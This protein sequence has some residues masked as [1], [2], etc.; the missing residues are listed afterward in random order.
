MDTGPP[1]DRQPRAPRRHPSGRRQ[2]A[3]DR[4]HGSKRRRAEYRRGLRHRK[5]RLGGG[6]QSPVP[7]RLPRVRAPAGRPHSHRRRRR[8]CGRPCR[9][10]GDL[11][12]RDRRVVVG[13]QYDL[14]PLSSLAD[15]PQRW[16]GPR[17]RWRGVQQRRDIRPRNQYVGS[18]SGARSAAP[19]SHGH[20]PAGRTGADRR[21]RTQTRDN[22]GHRRNLRSP[23]P[24]C[25]PPPA[26]W[27][28]RESLIAPSC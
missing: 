6:R 17:I 24:T 2:G 3:C 13:R 4:R 11:R 10:G 22:R 20:A 12:P 7:P 18:A 8:R 5:R 16:S 15:P 19:G 25:S 1:D 28:P 9:A 23:R 14:R 21:R 26:I 27:T